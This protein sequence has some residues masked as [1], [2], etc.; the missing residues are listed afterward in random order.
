ME[1]IRKIS[2]KFTHELSV[3]RVQLLFKWLENL[4]SI[5]ELPFDNFRMVTRSRGD[6]TFEPARTC[7][8]AL[9]KYPI[10]QLE[11]SWK[12]GTSLTFTKSL[13]S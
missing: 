7:Q 2:S 10:N 3:G 5:E 9:R 8:D 4:R 13:R 1:L 12:E 11:R 6:F